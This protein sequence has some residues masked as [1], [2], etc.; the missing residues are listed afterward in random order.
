[1][2]SKHKIEIIG[3]LT[4]ELS[5]DE[6]DF[7]KRLTQDYLGPPNQDELGSDREIRETLYKMTVSFI[8][9]VRDR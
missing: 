2:K 3:T 7:I 6:A 1:M 9:E 8:G 5:Y 4:L